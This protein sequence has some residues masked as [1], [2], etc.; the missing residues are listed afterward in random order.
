MAFQLTQLLL[1]AA[2]CACLL[3]PAVAGAQGETA[4]RVQAGGEPL[5]VVFTPFREAVL[6]ARVFSRVERVVKEMGQSFAEGDPLILLD[7][8][9]YAIN[10]DKSRAKAEAA[11]KNLEVARRLRA[12]KSISALDLEN[13][14]RDA[15]A[16]RADLAQDERELAACKTLAPFAGRVKK[17]FIHAHE[18]VDKGDPLVEI[19]DDAS[20]TAK[21]LAPSDLFGKVVVGEK[22]SIAVRETG[23]TVAGTVSHINEALDPA[24]G[25][26]EVYAVVDNA[27]QSLRSGMT[28]RLVPEGGGG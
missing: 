9:E 5:S 1:S 14:V 17:L 23:E 7:E 3:S 21:I 26:F 13:A 15:R 22:L 27:G 16:A 6:S 24:S 4:P 28:G 12:D 19:V 2:L 18:T 8:S 25:T 20:L 10:A 11:A